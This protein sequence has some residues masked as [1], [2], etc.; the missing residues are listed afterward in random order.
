[1][2][3]DFLDWRWLIFGYVDDRM[4]SMMALLY[5]LRSR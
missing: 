4:N 1:M 3:A 2:D 5:S